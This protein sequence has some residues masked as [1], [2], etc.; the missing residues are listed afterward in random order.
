[1]L[2]L[3]REVG[4]SIKSKFIKEQKASAILTILRQRDIKTLLSKIPVTDPLFLETLRHYN[5]KM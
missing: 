1:M 4:D 3:K 2:L 5:M